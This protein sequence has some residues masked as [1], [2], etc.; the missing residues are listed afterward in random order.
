MIYQCYD[1]VAKRVEGGRL[2]SDGRPL[3]YDRAMI[4]HRMG[5]AGAIATPYRKD[6]SRVLT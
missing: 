2:D 3:G 1:Y 4:A 5:R 6:A